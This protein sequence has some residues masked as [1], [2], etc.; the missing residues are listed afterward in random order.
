MHNSRALSAH[1]YQ[2]VPTCRRPT[3][4]ISHYNTLY[5]FLSPV[6]YI[7]IAQFHSLHV[8][9]S[10]FFF[11]EFFLIGRHS[12]RAKWNRKPPSRPI[13]K[14]VA[15]YNKYNIIIINYYWILVGKPLLI[16]TINDIRLYR[17][18]SS[19]YIYILQQVRRKWRSKHDTIRKDVKGIW[20]ELITNRDVVEEICNK[21]PLNEWIGHILGRGDLL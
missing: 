8:F 6:L 4:Y 15:Q 18:I 17:R 19:I 13:G 16:I 7:L 20:T 9:V 12:V 14:R 1:C 5:F 10:L 11:C 21:N 3:E 2:H